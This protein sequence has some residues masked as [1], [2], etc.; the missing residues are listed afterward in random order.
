MIEQGPLILYKMLLIILGGVLL[1][2]LVFPLIPGPIR[3]SLKELALNYKNSINELIT[4]IAGDDLDSLEDQFM[5]TFFTPF[6]LALFSVGIGVDYVF[7]FQGYYAVKYMIL[8]IGSTVLMFTIPTKEEINNILE[9]SEPRDRLLFLLK[10]IL[11]GVLTVQFPNLPVWIAYSI[12]F[13][14]NP[15]LPKLFETTALKP[16]SYK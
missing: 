14:P 13:A 2:L 11:A 16:L 3:E 1:R 15:S 12:P 4:V 9:E 8:L 7:T 10:L 5:T 6:A